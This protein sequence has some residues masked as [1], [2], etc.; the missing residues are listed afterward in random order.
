ME[1]SVE[2]LFKTRSL[3]DTKNK[4]KDLV[5]YSNI[6][7][8]IIVILII[9]LK[10][11]K[12][13]N[14]KLYIFSLVLLLLT[15]IISSIYHYHQCYDSNIDNVKHWLQCDVISAITLFILFV[16]LYNKNI[17][18]FVIILII[19]SLYLFIDCNNHD[20]NHTQETKDNKYI[21]MH[22]LWHI[23]VALITFILLIKD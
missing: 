5:I 23:I 18:I 4:H 17:N 8:V 16:I 13:K 11:D 9:Y 22:S 15:G 14:N 21:Y 10:Q 20:H 7:F 2:W 19:F 3:Y 12:L 6:I 1:S